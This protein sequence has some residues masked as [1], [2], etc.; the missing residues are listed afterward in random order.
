M[1]RKDRNL[2]AMVE[3]AIANYK[4][5]QQTVDL[6]NAQVALTLLLNKRKKK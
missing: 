3:N 1:K 5:T 4:E 2:V 6:E